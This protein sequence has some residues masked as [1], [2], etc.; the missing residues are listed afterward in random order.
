MVEDRDPFNVAR[1]PGWTTPDAEATRPGSGAGLRD[2]TETFS[3]SPA[4]G[5][6]SA[7]I[8]IASSAGRSGIDPAL[9][10]GYSSGAGNGP[11]G[12]GWQLNL[13]EIRRKTSAGVPHYSDA[14]DTFLLGSDD[15]V[16]AAA[17]D[18]A[19]TPLRDAAG[20]LVPDEAII[21]G[22]RVRRFR[23]RIE[24]AFARI[25]RWTRQADPSD[26]HW[27]LLTPDNVLSIFGATPDARITDPADPHR[28]AAWL[29][30]EV[31]D[32][33]GNLTLYRYKAEDGAA[34][35]LSAPQERNRGPRDSPR[36]GAARYLK[37]VFYGNRSSALDA[38][39]DRPRFISEAALAQRIADRDFLF[40]L[41]FDYG[42]HDAAAPTP[43]EANPWPVR[44]D[45]FSTYTYGFE[46]RHSRLCHRVLMFH[47]FENEPGV[48][49]DCLTGSTDFDFTALG[50]AALSGLTGVRQRG[51]VRDGVGGYSSQ[52]TPTARFHYATAEIATET[53]SIGADSS[54]GLPSGLRD[55][56]L[57][58]RDLHGVGLPGPLLVDDG[59]WR[60]K[61]N[62]G[63]LG[64]GAVSLGAP[65]LVAAR[66]NPQLLSGDGAL[67]DT[68]ASGAP[69]VVALGAVTPGLFRQGEAGAWQ[70]FQPFPAAP[71]EGLGDRPMRLFD[72]DGDGIMD[73][74][75]LTGDAVLYWHF[76]PA[77]GFDPPQRIPLPKNEEL[78]PRAV[79][80]DT[81]HAIF[82]ADMSGDGLTDIVRVRN[83]DV[84]YWPNLG[85]GR[86]GARVAMAGA[87]RFDDDGHFDPANIRLGDIDGTGTADLIYLHR[88]GVRLCVN[89]SGNGF[90]P[91][92]SVDILPE[93][94]SS[95][96]M[97]VVDL[98]GDG[99]ACLVWSTALGAGR[100]PALRYLRLMATGKP[101]L[102]TRTENGSG[103][104][105]RIT[106]TPSTAL[107]LRDL[108]AGRPWKTRLPF[109]V[110]VVTRIENFDFI[111]RTRA[112][113][114]FDYH[115]GH[116]DTNDREFRGFGMV[117]QRDAEE[118]GLYAQAIGDFGGV[119]AVEPDLLQPPVT[120]RTWYHLGNLVGTPVLAHPFAEEFHPGTAPLAPPVMPTGL[121]VADWQEAVRSLKGRV[122]RQEV[123][124]FDG[125]AD[126][127]VPYSVTER[128]YE[129]RLLQPRD[130]A[131]PAACA[132]FDIETLSTSYDRV[133]N[134][135]RITQSLA[136]DV[137]PHGETERVINVVYGRAAPDPALPAA[138]RAAQARRSLTVSTQTHTAILGDA[139]G[140]AHYR[141]PVPWATEAF[142][143]TGAAPAGARFSL[144]E[145]RAADDAAAAAPIGF[146]EAPD[147]AQ[148]QR[149]RLGRARI[150]FRAPDLAPLAF[151][152]TSWRGLPHQSFTLAFTDAI[153]ADY[154]GSVGAA[155][156]AAAGYVQLPGEPGWWRPSGLAVYGADPRA[157]FFARQGNRDV[158]GLETLIERDVYEL[159]TTAVSVTTA[160]WTRAS[161]T[162]DYRTLAANLTTD[163]NGNRAAIAF[164]ELGRITRTAV[165]GKVGDGDGD[166]LADP[167]ATV[168]YD[169]LAW[170]DRREP[171]H[172]ITRT[173]ERHGD[174]GSPVQE[175]HAYHDGSGRVSLTKTRAAPGLALHLA[176]D[177]TVTEVAADPRWV[178]GGRS[179]LNNK[180]LPVRGYEPYFSDTSAYE[181]ERAL[182]ERGAATTT[183]YDPLGRPLRAEAPDGTL[184]RTEYG[185]WRT[186]TFDAN[187]TV[188]DSQWYLDRGAPDPAGPQPANADTRAAWLAARHA[189]TPTER[190]SDSH[191]G[192]VL[193]RVSRGG[194]VS[195]DIVTETDA[196][197]RITRIHDQLGR[198]TTE[199]VTG[200]AGQAISGWNAERGRRFTFSDALGRLVQSWDE[201]GRSYRPLYDS[202]HRMTGVFVRDGAG[203]E[204]LLTYI[205]Y[206]DRLPDGTI[207]TP[208]YDEGNAV[209]ALSAQIGGVGAPIE[210]LRGQDYD[211]RGRRLRA[212]HGNGCTTRHSYDPRSQRLTRLLTER[213]AAPA[214]AN[215]LRDLR[216]TYDAIGN[217]TTLADLAQQD[218]YFANAVVGAERLFEYD[219]FYQLIRAEGRE[220]AS[221]AN[222]AIRGPTDGPALAGLPH[223]ND[224]N[225]VRR[226]RETYSYDLAGN[227]T[228]LTHRFLTGPAAGNGWTRQYRY[229]RD[230]NPADLTNRLV[231]TTGPADAPG[232][233]PGLTYDYD[234]TGNMIR[235]PHL[236]T[237]DWD[238]T[239]RLSHVDLGGGGEAFYA[240]GGDG[241]RVRKVIDRPG[242]LREEW[243]TLGALMIYRR[244]RRDTGALRFERRTLSLGEPGGGIAAEIYTKT[245]DADGF[246][247]ANPVGARLVTYQYSDPLGGGTIETDPAG[248]VI[249]AETYHPFG[250]TALRQR[251]PGRDLSL[252]RYRFAG[253]ERDDETGLQPMGA[254]LYAP[255]LG[256]WISADP[257]GLAGG[258]NL[259]QYCAN[260]PVMHRDPMGTKWEPVGDFV[261]PD[262][263]DFA[264]GAS[265]STVRAAFLEHGF[266]TT[267]TFRNTD[268]GQVVTLGVHV[269]LRSVG[270]MSQE[271]QVGGP[272][273]GQQFWQ[274]QDFEVAELN[275]YR[276]DQPA[277]AESSGSGGQGESAGD[278]TGTEGPNGTNAGEGPPSDATPGE[279]AGG[280]GEADSGDGAT[281]TGSGD[282]DGGGDGE[283]DE[284]LDAR[285]DAATHAGPGLER[286]IWS[287]SFRDRGFTLEHLYN[288]DLVNAWR[289]T[290]D[291][292]PLYDV[293]NATHV[294]QIKS[295]N[296]RPAGIRAHA[297]KATRDAGTAI[298]RNPTDS[299]TGKSPQAVVITPTD[300]PATT[301]AD[302]RAG[303][304]NIRRPPPNATPPEHVRGLPGVLGKIG[305]GLTVAGT[306]LS[307]FSLGQDLAAG[308]YTM[309]GADAI[310]T[311]GGALEI[312]ALAT[313]GATVAGVSAMSAGLAVGG[314]GI[315]AGS[316]ISGVRA[317]QRGDYFG[318]GLGVAGFL[319]GAAITLG[320]I[321]SAPALLIGGLVAAAVV[322]LV[323]LGRW[324]L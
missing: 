75:T 54:A 1:R 49:L 113:R 267:R 310:S 315:M 280:E 48:G 20:H 33:F 125:G 118:F 30:G 285:P 121:S 312:Y 253:H 134:D 145:L 34:L 278:A 52:E 229:A 318:A 242:N 272:H 81:A 74:I 59:A 128:R 31:R 302:I 71:V 187:D 84:C 12:L 130:G 139:T 319:A 324:L 172:T 217:V 91:I 168:I 27:R 311:A 77:T 235:M 107:Y 89:Q 282:G 252:K 154:G 10:L 44:A 13:P 305:R 232:A 192:P 201:H 289:A 293:E 3:V 38:Q 179:I 163:P 182:R 73:G 224:V 281:D 101:H 279:S 43:A 93:A 129:V 207:L 265:E 133:A 41:V 283:G 155:E 67:F 92:Q 68:S 303:Y 248:T 237:L 262:P 296:A 249:S 263:P 127:D 227:I 167:T 86:F 181:D 78:G 197:R 264:H 60:F 209:R 82:L 146:T 225:A 56:A 230:D 251:A 266:H 104:E 103:A 199:V 29:L 72:A 151:G 231:A 37:S 35:D 219:A 25:E 313:P 314:V 116:Y 277:D 51:Y 194:G 306:G 215:P 8:A 7:G 274:L 23:Q 11:F 243:I 198:M 85:H 246:D 301:A 190:H 21:D 132:A 276:L 244:R 241:T 39:S 222:D 18:G 180:G 164:D 80:D 58:W 322:G 239:D 4:T 228:S 273:R 261:N 304:D 206:G 226:Y 221:L 191:G 297:S 288:N 214:G 177:G 240:H 260:N 157:A 55:S 126:Q 45:P 298:R 307:A 290:G 9:A 158:F 193:L 292:R 255:W 212:E 160:A 149:R 257:A 299:M 178:G 236:D 53:G 50:P 162:N 250:T 26:I 320:V 98:F 137:G 234:P 63:P 223:P 170:Q 5:L 256:R 136:L 211:A 295:S 140:A 286:G 169:S 196:T 106:Y 79:F 46:L 24:G 42:E 70:S 195:A 176:A 144:A 220:H 124:S 153:L 186:L 156:L 165:M 161:S 66:P 287:R 321:F 109:P 141:L 147:P 123:Y 233:P 271:T 203:P 117:E 15:L 213:D 189:D 83:G 269:K 6:G 323:H 200:L 87:P 108:E 300:A 216:F 111:A 210:I 204:A 97:Q 94:D 115:H 19:G 316:A 148:V 100:G 284:P 122:I 309:A 317:Y 69:D 259:Y 183:F 102:L 131:S 36:R 65:E 142:E 208:Q 114:E 184:S 2:I 205:V 175:S 47:H 291:N 245:V 57:I 119:Q 247:L 238:R 99:L 185:A 218:I 120:S 159:L 138:V 275:Y 96:D 174:P 32:P 64:G 143:L 76:D 166:T 150:R 152:Q 16:T 254:R 270:R 202:L 22:F 188:L 40:Q 268:T 105:T 62:R 90:S 95:S 28:I 294:K 112:T 258:L 171:I 173:R 308:D 135:P 14:T 61:P 17:R 110:H 88:A